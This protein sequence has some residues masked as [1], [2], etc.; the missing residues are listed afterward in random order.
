MQ[1]KPHLSNDTNGIVPAVGIILMLIIT[2]ILA[3]V[4]GISAFD[5]TDKLKEP[6]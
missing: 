2:I 5:I 6:P 1:L 4:I 3:A